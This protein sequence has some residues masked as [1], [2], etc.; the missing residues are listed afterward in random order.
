MTKINTNPCFLYTIKKSYNLHCF[1]MQ[2]VISNKGSMCQ[3][4][5]NNYNYLNKDNIKAL[6]FIQNYTVS[7]ET[8]FTSLTGVIKV[9]QDVFLT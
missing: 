7:I 1:F 9:K 6:A 5:L 8:A 3:K 4:Q 2:V